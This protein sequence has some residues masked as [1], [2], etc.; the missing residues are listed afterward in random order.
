[1][2]TVYHRDQA[3]APALTYTASAQAGFNAFKAILK[4]CLVNG[5][6]AVPAAGWE[7]INEG[8]G[9]LVLRNGA[10]SGYVCFTLVSNAMRV[11]LADT[12]TGM[13]GD[14]MTGAGVKSGRAA[15]S[16]V[17][18][19]LQ[20]IY[21]ASSTVNTSWVVIADEKTFVITLFGDSSW[22]NRELNNN[23]NGSAC[24]TL[25]VGEDSE[26]F[27]IAAGGGADASTS[28]G[29]T[30]LA[31]SGGFT[32]VKN[33]ATG[34]LVGG[35]ALAIYIPAMV[36]SQDNL[37]IAAAAA[38]SVAALPAVS[39]VPVGW[40]VAGAVAGRF[41]GVALCPDVQAVTHA[42]IAAQYLG[43]PTPM[44]LRDGNQAIDL[45]DVHSYFVRAGN[46]SSAFWLI[47]D[48]PEFW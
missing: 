29:A 14:V 21:V 39:L 38:S 9:F 36:M 32:A 11:Y 31:Y 17:H 23:V 3:G 34:L 41:R 44:Y 5:Y 18:Q 4:A 1:M 27:F 10:H 30:V 46:P 24:H 15:G 13:S 8:T 12:Y 16:T 26:G 22:T 20:I 2:A 40:Q 47:T 48:N 28:G 35:D 45:G 7:L 6:G 43:R 42:S 33:P 25:C 19:S 37:G